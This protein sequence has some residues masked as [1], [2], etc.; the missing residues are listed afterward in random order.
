MTTIVMWFKRYM[1]VVPGLTQHLEPIEGGIYIP[2]LTESVL[3][4]GSFAFFAILM[5]SM[6]RFFP[7][8]SIWEV[9]DQDRSME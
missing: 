9:E 4:V 8:V 3:M 6:S 2:T 7:M 1:V 5:V